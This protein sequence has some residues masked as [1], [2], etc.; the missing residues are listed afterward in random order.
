MSV[1]SVVAEGDRIELA[2]VSKAMAGLRI[3]QSSWWELALSC[4]LRGIAHQ[5]KMRSQ[6]AAA[7]LLTAVQAFQRNLKLQAAGNTYS[8]K[9]TASHCSIAALVA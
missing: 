8:T 9:T 3:L 6:N 4:L 1:S 2:K 5:S 7:E